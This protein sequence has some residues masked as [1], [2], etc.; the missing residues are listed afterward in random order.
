[1]RILLVKKYYFKNKQY[2]KV[3]YEKILKDYRLDTFSGIEKAQKEYDD[4]ILKYPHK[5]ANNIQNINSTGDVVSQSKNT[6]NCFIVKSFENCSYCDFCTRD[7]EAYDLTVSGELS[8]CYEG[9]VVDHSQ[10]NLFGIF[11]PKCQDVKYTQHC[12]NCK[13][14]IG[15][16]ALRNS[17]Y[18][19][20]NKQY[21]KE[22]YK[23]LLPKIIKHMNDMPFI[24]KKEMNTNLV[25]FFLLNFHHLAITKLKRQNNFRLKK[26]KRLKMDISG[27]TILNT[28]LAKKQ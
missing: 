26:M 7:K 14:S 12:H 2:E 18:C 17:N 19:I 22:E 10:L 8:E 16:D 6:Q 28:L 24:D 4:F 20:L 21:T 25:N 23:E 15:Y 1:M 9:I 3:E 5:Y 27:K 13:Y 11:S